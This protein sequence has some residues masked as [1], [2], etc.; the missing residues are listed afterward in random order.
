MTD[1][2]TAIARGLHALIQGVFPDAIRSQDKGDTGYGFGRGYKG[3]VFVVSPHARHV[4]LGVAHGA[5]LQ[6]SF[7]I[8]QGTGKVHRH[9]KLASLNDL[10]NPDLTKLMN[11]ALEAARA[12]QEARQ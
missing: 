3:L 4:N 6:S 11:A 9:V 10:A 5:Q 1:Q 2:V 12:R 7:P 8:L